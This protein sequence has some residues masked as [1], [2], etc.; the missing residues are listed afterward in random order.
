MKNEDVSL[1]LTGWNLYW[2]SFSAYWPAQWL[3]TT[4]ND[5]DWFAPLYET[6]E[7]HHILLLSPNYIN[8][9]TLLFFQDSYAFF[10]DPWNKLSRFKC[11]K[12]FLLINI[13]ELWEY[14][15]WMNFH[16]TTSRMYGKRDLCPNY[17][18]FLNSV[19]PILREGPFGFLDYKMQAIPQNQ[20]PVISQMSL[21]L[22]E[23]S[24]Q[25]MISNGFVEIKKE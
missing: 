17:I 1:S 14:S 9:N 6:T 15:E 16:S 10:T 22:Q 8:N 11:Q 19:M 21:F 7:K 12:H 18:P 23:R 4:Q 3:W 25:Y 20:N 2:V 5:V 13:P 24:L